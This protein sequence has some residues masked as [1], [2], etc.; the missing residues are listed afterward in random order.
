MVTRRASPP[1]SLPITRRT[2]TDLYARSADHG[3]LGKKPSFP[4]RKRR[5]FVVHTRAD[6]V[7]AAKCQGAGTSRPCSTPSRLRSGSSEMRAVDRRSDDVRLLV[8]RGGSLLS[9][10]APLLRVGNR[11][12]RRCGH[13]A[14]LLAARPRG[15]ARSTLHRS[16][17]PASRGTA[18]AS[19]PLGLMSEVAEQF[20]RGTPTLREV[21]DDPPS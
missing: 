13:L 7:P 12:P 9:G 20:R 8:F 2:W 21:L 16:G 6:R 19:D 3:F 1:A 5:R 11:L 10:P 14:L 4:D 15:A 17:I 18:A